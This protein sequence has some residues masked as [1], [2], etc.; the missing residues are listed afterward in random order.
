MHVG[1][2]W[3]SRW[4][5]RLALGLA[6]L[7]TV[8][9]AGCTTDSQ[10][11]VAAPTGGATPGT[12]A[13]GA[14]GSIPSQPVQ[15]TPVVG[16]CRGPVTATIIDAPTDPR[17]VVPCDQPHGNETFF[18]GTMDPSITSWPGEDTSTTTFDRQVDQACTSRHEAYVGLAA[19]AAEA[20]PP[21]RVQSFAYFVPTKSDFAAG[22]RWFR[23]DAVVEPVDPGEATTIVGTLK[24]VYAQPLP[25]GYRVCEAALNRLT[26][27]AK[28]HLVE[29]LATVQLPDVTEYPAPRNDVAVTAACRAPLLAAL[30]LT[31][32]RTDLA[33]GYVLPSQDVWDAGLQTAT[34]VAGA[35]DNAALDDTLYRIG[36]TKPLPLASK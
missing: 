24:D 15:A 1:R 30:G 26:A 3:G 4:A 17:P 23:C 13:P 10:V 18:V 5:R 25:V 16:E 33:F 19:A 20:L 2:R 14:G 35:A 9:A 31:G 36:P 22:A 12:A 6:G 7:V 11:Q 27:C 29:Y 21:D 8:V 34:C 32:E 28:K